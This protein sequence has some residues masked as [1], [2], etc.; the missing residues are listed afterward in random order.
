MDSL[1]TQIL[2]NFKAAYGLKITDSSDMFLTEKNLLEFLMRLGRATMGAVFEQL[3]TGYEGAVIRKDARKYKF[4]GYRRT[5]LHGLFGMVEYRR[6]YY[7]SKQE[8]GGGYFPQDEK[9]GIQMRHT[10]RLPVLSLL[11]YRAGGLSKEPG[12]VSR[13]LSP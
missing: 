10:P 2:E 11:L 13:D 6:A 7:F 5:S 8:G 12:S 3:D 9:L 4:V 1:V